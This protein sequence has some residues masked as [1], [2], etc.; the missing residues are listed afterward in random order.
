[1]LDA[2]DQVAAGYA[3]LILRLVGG[4]RLRVGVSWL[5][6]GIRLGLGRGLAVLGLSLISGLMIGLV[7]RLLLV[8][9]MRLGRRCCRNLVCLARVAVPLLVLFDIAKWVGTYR[10]FTHF[11]ISKGI[12]IRKILP[13]IYM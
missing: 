8:R 6:L 10:A 1:M 12:I 9:S 13:C 5:G 7:R 11:S 2:A 3:R 4:L